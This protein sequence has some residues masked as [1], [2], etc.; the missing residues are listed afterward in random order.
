MIG[1][2]INRPSNPKSAVS[3]PP[4]QTLAGRSSLQA[5]TF[6]ITTLARMILHMSPAASFK[7]Q[8]LYT[9]AVA[10]SMI[11]SEFQIMQ[12]KSA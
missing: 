6:V 9:L 8:I 5:G 12:P 7:F 1:Q 11:V 10:W 4:S 3:A 2:G